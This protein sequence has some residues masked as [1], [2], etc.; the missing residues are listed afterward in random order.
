MFHKRVFLEEER[1]DM[2]I[3]VASTSSV[4]R[5]ALRDRIKNYVRTD[6]L[7]IERE[8]RSQI[9]GPV[10]MINEVSRYIVDSGGKR[11]RPLLTILCA[12]LCGYQGTKDVP[13]AIAFEFLHAATLLHDDVIDHAEV[14]R[15]K[16]AAN[17]LWGNQAVV[18]V[19]D[20]LYSKSLMLSLEYENLKIVEIITKAVNLMAEGEI[21]QLMYLGN[22]DITEEEYLEIVRRKTA[23]LISSACQA[24]A[25]LG[26][27]TA[28]QEEL[29]HRYG[30]NLGVAFQ[31]MDDVLDYT[32]T[33][34]QLG[35][36]VGKDLEENKATLPLIYALASAD[37]MKQME[38]R[39]A[40]LESSRDSNSL[41][42]VKDFVCESG[43]VE[44]T[45]A[46]A[47]EHARNAQ[48]CLNIFP[49][50]EVKDVLMDI[51]EYVIVRQD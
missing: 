14:R 1:K 46:R 10:S 47:I 19:G 15:N 40:F 27:A 22:P 35:K 42:V 26:G 3:N 25:I 32:G 33:E 34:E 23:V 5:Y 2:E 11:L 37:R 21:L 9:F 49:K 13:L 29:L 48:K 38:I 24:G 45:T 28:E 31:L 36:P 6:L 4:G 17:T 7:R 41:Q 16:P 8:I 50:S 12:R 39:K 43:G 51:A 44:Y 20:Y 30:Y 18:L